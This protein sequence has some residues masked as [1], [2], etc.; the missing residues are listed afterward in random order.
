MP[1][2][3]EACLLQSPYF[4]TFAA[5]GAK[6]SVFLRYGHIYFGFNF[7]DGAWTRENK[8]TAK[9][10]RKRYIYPCVDIVRTCRQWREEVRTRERT[11]CSTSGARVFLHK[12]SGI[13]GH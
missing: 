13:Y 2:Y 8:S 12:C 10:Q 11:G 4:V 5:L 1:Y 3:I 6:W 9:I 7:A